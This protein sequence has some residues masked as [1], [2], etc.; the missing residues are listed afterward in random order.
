MFHLKRNPSTLF[1]T[2]A[3]ASPLLKTRRVVSRGTR[4]SYKGCSL[5]CHR[6]LVS[7]NVLLQGST[8]WRKCKR[9]NR[10]TRPIA[11]VFELFLSPLQHNEEPLRDARLTLLAEYLHI[12]SSEPSRKARRGPHLGTL[13]KC[14]SVLCTK[15][16]HGSCTV[17]A[18]CTS[19][20]YSNRS[21]E[22]SGASLG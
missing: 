12:P 21:H 20:T 4:A 16:S 11:R 14:T 17:S 18:L 2:I 19:W 7:Y 8:C 10:G 3:V 1:V 22:M 15:T 9:A 6:A 13:S 5:R